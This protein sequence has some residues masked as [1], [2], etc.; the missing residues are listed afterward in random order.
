MAQLSH[1]CALLLILLLYLANKFTVFNKFEI[2][3][4]DTTI[5]NTTS[6]NTTSTNTTIPL[7]E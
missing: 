4:I 2:P 5:T 7:N 3:N 6:T 1:P